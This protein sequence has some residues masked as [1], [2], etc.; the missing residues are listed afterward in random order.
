MDEIGGVGDGGVD[1]I[2]RSNGDG[3]IAH[4]VQCKRYIDWKVGVAEVRDFL[5]QWRH[6]SRCEGVFVTCGRYTSEARAFATG[7]PIRLIDGDELLS[8]LCAANPLASSR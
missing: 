6:Q 1:L 5:A 4:L 8:M 3:S 7:K 2:L